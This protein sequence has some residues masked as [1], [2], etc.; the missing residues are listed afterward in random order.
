MAQLKIVP[1]K[2]GD[3]PLAPA[4]ADAIRKAGFDPAKFTV[5]PMSAD[6]TLDPTFPHAGQRAR[7]KFRFPTLNAAFAAIERVLDRDVVASIASDDGAYLVT[8]DIASGADDASAHAAL[9]QRVRDL[10]GEDVGL[11]RETV[12][13]NT[14]VLPR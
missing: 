2:D 12:A 10:A 1:R 8:F 9:A 6:A 14:R 4:I 13:I 11:T 5:S 3:P 7:H